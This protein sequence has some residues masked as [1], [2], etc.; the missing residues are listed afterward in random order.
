MCDKSTW[1]GN[2]RSITIRDEYSND[3]IEGVKVQ[4]YAGETC[5]LGN[6]DSAGKLK[7]Q[8]PDAYGY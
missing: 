1:T 6:T 5:T 7:T 3:L 4:Y 8:M 2:N